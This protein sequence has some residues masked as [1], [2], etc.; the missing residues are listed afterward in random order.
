MTKVVKVYSSGA[1][2]PNILKSHFAPKSKVR[3]PVIIKGQL[4]WL[5]PTA[6]KRL[7]HKKAKA[8]PSS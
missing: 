3:L 6:Y 4:L 1:E 7:R 8:C 2:L 5:T